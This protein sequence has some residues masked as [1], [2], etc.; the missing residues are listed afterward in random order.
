MDSWTKHTG[1]QCLV[2]KMKRKPERD[3]LTAGIFTLDKTHLR[4]I[5]SV[6]PSTILSRIDFYQTLSL[7]MC[8]NMGHQASVI[9]AAHL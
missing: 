6:F 4:E 1:K 8:M 3:T 5:T 7:Q 9:T 2:C